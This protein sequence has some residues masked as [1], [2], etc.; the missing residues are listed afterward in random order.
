MPGAR[1][2]PVDEERGHKRRR[3]PEGGDG[4]VVADPEGTV[5]HVGREHLDERGRA[6]AGEQGDDE[7]EEYLPEHYE[8]NAPVE[9]S[10]NRG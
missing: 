1:L 3:A 7:A 2:L 10:R 9:T 4:Q 8:G 5:A 6:G